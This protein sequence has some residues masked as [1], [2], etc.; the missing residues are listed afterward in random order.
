MIRIV[1]LLALL[2]LQPAPVRAQDTRVILQQDGSVLGAT[3]ILNCI[4]L[5]CSV[6]NGIG[7]LQGAGGGAIALATAID[8]SFS[9][10]AVSNTVTE[11]SLYSYT[12]PGNAIG[13]DFCISQTVIGT[14]TGN[15][16]GVLTLRAKYGSGVATA[17]VTPAAVTDE[18]F[19]TEVILCG[20]GATNAQQL[21]MRSG[22]GNAILERGDQSTIAVDS[23][24]SQTF[25]ITAQW[26]TASSALSV[27]KL[28]AQTGT[29]GAATTST[30]GLAD[31][32]TNGII[33]R[34]ALNV[35]APAVAG[36]DYVLPSGSITG[37]AAT[38][39]AL[40]TPPTL[41]AVGNAIRGVDAQGNAQGEFDV[42][43]PGELAAWVPATATALVA[44]GTNAAP[45]FAI[46]GVDALGNF[47]GAFDVATQTE[48][49]NWV[50]ATATALAADGA[51]ATNAGFAITG[52]DAQGNAQGEFDV[53]TQL[54]LN[55]HASAVSA[56]GATSSP[57]P[58]RIPLSGGAGTLDGG[59]L[60][61]PTLT[62]RGGVL[63]SSYCDATVGKQIGIGTDGLPVCATDQNSGGP[64]GGPSTDTLQD[65][66]S[67][68]ST[69]T[70]AVSEASALQVGG[71]I[72][73]MKIWGSPTD[74]V[75]QKVQ[76]AQNLSWMLG[77]NFN[78]SF[79]DAAGSPILSMAES[80]KTTTFYGPIVTA[81]GQPTLVAPVAAIGTQK[82]ASISAAGIATLAPDVQPTIIHGPPSAG[83]CIAANDIFIDDTSTPPAL[84]FCK[85]AGG[86]PIDVATLGN[87]YVILS[88]GTLT[89]TP[90]G[91]EQLTFLA[92]TGSILVPKVTAGTPDTFRYNFAPQA[93][94]TVLAGPTSGGPAVPTFRA[95]PIVFAEMSA[96]LVA[97]IDQL[98]ARLAV[99]E[100]ATAGIATTH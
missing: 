91:A 47:E 74:G 46:T 67:R 36:T 93:A 34:T 52:V 87:S 27:S 54:E 97:R 2:V 16:A 1:L 90:A 58:N 89:V 51:N 33:K 21:I 55:A 26:G 29:G 68:G 98:E 82:I 96:P 7:N 60:P 5:T 41:G 59:W 18:Y 31:P 75:V 85:V 12:L 40:A 57:T 45:G 28:Y 69:I 62:T 19:S 48:L 39:T 17:V 6:V 99:L 32:G 70:T 10:V 53:A 80:T 61:L 49:N 100:G 8:R 38:A 78:A 9:N 86:N 63:S 23:T 22:A 4:G 13:T 76:P 65:V 50:P 88:D 20:D 14:V 24:T 79:V 84:Y 71:P 73:L 11:T 25:E 94:N 37:N 43:T 66:F 42:I 95:G 30:P 44:N 83:S 92:D 3:R 15:N 72:Y 77:D 81:A 64:G 35:T 56:H